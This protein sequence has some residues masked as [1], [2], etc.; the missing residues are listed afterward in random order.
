MQKGDMIMNVLAIGAHF[1]DIELGCS[2]SLKKHTEKGDKVI[3]YVATKSGFS[4]PNKEAVRSDAEAMAEGEAAA[5]LIGGQLICGGFET[6][7]LEFED[8]LN[9]QLVQL[10]EREQIDLIYT[11]DKNDVHHDHIAL[12]KASLHSGRHVPRILTYHSN[13]YQ[14]DVRFTPDFYQDI[15]DTWDTKEAVIKAHRSEY[16]RVGDAW[17]DYF[18]K[19]AQNN[20]FVCGVKLA[21]GFRCIKWLA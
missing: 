17:V 12:A 4:A 9:A 10:I 3:L 2:G 15:T 8:T 7:K 13:W 18:Y 5:K 14:S 1:D 16:E 19:E 21:E 11:H 20:G 6:L